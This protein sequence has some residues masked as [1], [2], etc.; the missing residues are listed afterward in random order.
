MLQIP[1]REFHNDLFLPVYQGEFYS[2]QD[3]EGRLYTGDTLPRKYTPKH[4]NST[5][6]INNITCVCE[7]CIRAMFLKSD[8]NKLQ[9]RLLDFFEKLYHNFA[10][11]RILQITNKYHNE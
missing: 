11:I 5:R 7:T 6:N 8:L 9:L 2:A 4:I 3:E 10:T 1:V